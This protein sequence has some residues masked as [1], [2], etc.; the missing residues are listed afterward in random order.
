MFGR[1]LGIAEAMQGTLEY[2]LG[3][4]IV[5]EWSRAGAECSRVGRLGDGLAVGVI[6]ARLG[7]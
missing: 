4:S 6:D 5:G 7:Y 3:Y 1:V 2:N